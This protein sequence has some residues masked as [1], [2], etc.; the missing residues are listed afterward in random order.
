MTR[1]GIEGYDIIGDIHGYI[2]ALEE[3]LD[4]LGYSYLDSTWQHPSRRAVFVGDFICR[5]PGSRKVI[6]TIRSMVNA[7]YAHAILG[8][9][10]LNAIMLFTKNDG[11]PIHEPS[12]T[13]RQVLMRMAS[14][15]SRNIDAFADDIKWLR[16]LP[17]FLDF[18][19][20]RVVHAYWSN[21]NIGQLNSLH[22]DGKIKKKKLKEIAAGESPLSQ[23]V[24]ETVR[25]IIFNL[26]AD[27]IV[28]DSK[29]VSRNSFRI[30]WLMPM[31]GKTFA[32]ISFGS[33]FVLPRYTIP[34]QLVKEYE[35]YQP[36]EPL[37]FVGHYCM[38]HHLVQTANICC[39]DA[40]ISSGGRLAAYRY[41][42]E[43]TIS[44]EK[45]V[46]VKPV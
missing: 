5:G 28:K 26:P 21:T 20:F 45:F 37:L 8:N 23:A 25:G 41:D 7:G 31:K 14:E 1:P 29:N 40:C 4:K 35:V 3:L 9:H 44:D 43:K 16:S 12:K 24:N 18:G 22:K 19:S 34:D 27:L 32:D 39:V 13:N 6:S 36:E 11:I 46:F 17:F 42:G 33:R 2:D 30:K 10:E 38:S 15:Y